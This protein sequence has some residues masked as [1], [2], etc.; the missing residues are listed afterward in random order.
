MRG[1]V[2]PAPSSVTRL[3]LESLWAP[4]SAPPSVGPTPDERQ[5]V[6][7]LITRLAKHDTKPA[8]NPQMP[9][10]YRK[11]GVSEP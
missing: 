10:R 1:A 9:A 7:A 5:Y 3:L 6:L 11:S 4:K 2:Q 8:T